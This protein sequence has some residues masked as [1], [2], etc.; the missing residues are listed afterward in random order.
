MLD[1]A[2][3]YAV[4][5]RG[6]ARGATSLA[7]IDGL[8]YVGTSSGAIYAV[9]S[10]EALPPA[11]RAVEQLG[12]VP[13]TSLRA[14]LSDQHVWVFSRGSS[15]H[16]CL[17]LTRGARAFAAT[18]WREAHDDE[19][20][21]RAVGLRGMDELAA[22]KR[23]PAARDARVSILAVACR[24]H[25]AVYRWL[26]GVFYDAKEV[27][28][29]RAPQTV[30][31]LSDTLYVGCAVGD[32][33][34]ISVPPAPSS[35]VAWRVAP[36]DALT[37]GTWVDAGAWPVYA[38]ALPPARERSWAPLRRRGM[39]LLVALDD[40]VLAVT[41]SAGVVLDAAGRVRPERLSWDAPPMHIAAALPY[42]VV[43]ESSSALRVYLRDTLRLAQ[44]LALPADVRILAPGTTHRAVAL[45]GS[46]VYELVPAAL[47]DQVD[48]LRSAG[49]YVDALALLRTL[50]DDALPDVAERRAHMQALVGVVR[51]AEGAFDAAIDLFIEVDANPTKV[52]ALYPVEVAGHLSQ[53]PKTWLRLWGEDREIEHVES[54]AGVGAALDSLVRFLNDRRQRLKA[55]SA[56]KDAADT[57][58]A[59]DTP[60]D[61]PL[62][63]A[64]PYAPLLGTT[65]L[66]AAAQA[67]DTALLKAFLLTKPA[68]VGALCRVDN[69][70]DVP[71][72]A[73][74]LRAQ[75]RFHELVSLYRG[76]R[77]HREALALL[78]ER[79]TGDSADAR[80]APTVE[81]VAALGADDADAVLEAAG[82]VLSL[83]PRAGLAL[84]TGEQL[85]V[86]PPRRVVDT[87][88]EADPFLADEYIASVV[89][90]GCMDPALHTRLAK[91]Y[92][93]AASHSAEPHKDAALNFLR[94][95]PAYDAASL[96]TMLPAEP[97]LPAVRAEL[98]GRL[99][100]HRDALRLYVEGMHDIA[101]AEAYCDEHADAGSD[102]FTTL[103]R[104]VRAS[105]PHHLPDVLAL[106]ARH[107]AT[108]DLDAVLAL[109]PPSCT[110]HDVA[111]L[112]DHAFRVQAARRD[113]LRME[114]AMCTARN[115][116]LDRALRARH[117]Q[118]VVVAAGRTCTRCQRRL[119]NAVLAVMPTTGATMHYSCAEGLGSRKPIPD[120]HNS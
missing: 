119:G 86:L 113:A 94:S 25:V 115:T 38:V 62:D 44:E 9:E 108:V 103:V 26:D 5:A 24:R 7:Q 56:A 57:A 88:D 39:P 78:R 89:A 92:V 118:H 34:R 22:A 6:A 46:T 120:G 68:L 80:V 31:A 102:L 55:L 83:A 71:A 13:G 61:I 18:T 10:D 21:A 117:A 105:A 82:W 45:A 101:Q 96:L 91:V 49:E 95:S 30:A 41:E 1:R 97:A 53:K 28:M 76:K 109:L 60:A 110:V 29:P 54:D 27:A 107:A 11:R 116:A 14:V 3:V 66:R 35:S 64:P 58:A 77:M 87:L 111:P 67:V 8:T 99:G 32:Y 33:V 37:S 19:T 51:F 84:F 93:D 16:T 79:A 98:L 40:G 85:G 69:H 15:V 47:A 20:S 52:L 74:L 36:S 50:Q 48:V 100:R 17:P 75:E 90:Q 106:L 42:L 12:A 23:V 65:Q 59:S 63:K 81:Y 72:V 2:G 4:E 104:L 73:P 43:H 112:L 114:R 70:C